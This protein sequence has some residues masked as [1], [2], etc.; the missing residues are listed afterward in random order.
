MATRQRKPTTKQQI[1][2]MRAKVEKSGAA[3]S[4]LIT[5]TL[6]RYEEQLESL[7]RLSK[8]IKDESLLLEKEGKNG[9]ESVIN[10]ALAEY[11]RTATA[12]NNTASTLVRIMKD[13]A[14][15]TLL[16]GSEDD[17]GL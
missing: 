8:I 10:P 1:S 9:S 11:N 14:A 16:N 4:V 3:N 2:Q 5:T 13:V 17:D 12:A 7:K 6:D 15:N